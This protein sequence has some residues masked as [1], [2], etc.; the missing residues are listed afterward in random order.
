VPRFNCCDAAASEVQPR[1]MITVAPGAVKTDLLGASY[2][3]IICRRLQSSRAG[4]C[5]P[6]S[7]V[8]I[9]SGSRLR[10]GR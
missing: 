3:R 9:R 8:G 10:R 7:A 5:P 1:S 2:I 4:L 6:G